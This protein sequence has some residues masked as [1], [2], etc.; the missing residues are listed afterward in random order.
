[1]TLPAGYGF[2]LQLLQLKIWAD[3]I[4]SSLLVTKYWMMDIGAGS[5]DWIA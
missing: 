1:M 4:A 2:F 5:I 3:V